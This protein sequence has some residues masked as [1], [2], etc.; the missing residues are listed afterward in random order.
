MLIGSLLLRIPTEKVSNSIFYALT[1][2]VALTMAIHLLWLIFGLDLGHL[3]RG[4]APA[5]AGVLLVYVFD[6]LVLV[7]I[8]VDGI[9]V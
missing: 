9:F 2:L 8:H 6:L 4:A 1:S 5:V 7:L 3:A